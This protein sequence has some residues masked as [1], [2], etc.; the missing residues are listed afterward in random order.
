[1]GMSE[2]FIGADT[3]QEQ[4]TAMG[5][6]LPSMDY[7]LNVDSS[8]LPMHAAPNLIRPHDQQ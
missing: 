7:H 5:V 3:K 4:L 1:M 8:L 6:I 2:S